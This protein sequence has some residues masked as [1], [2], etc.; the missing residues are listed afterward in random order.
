M[1]YFYV[2]RFVKNGKLY[3]GLTSDLK[4]RILEHRN[5][6]SSFTSKNGSFDLIFY[7][8]YIDKKDAIE[9]EKYFKTGHGREVLKGKLKNFL[10]RVA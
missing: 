10:G 2:I 6:V 7:E 9:A 1:Y 4:R 8:A 5:G 3:K